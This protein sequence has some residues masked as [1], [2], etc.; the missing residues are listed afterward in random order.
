LDYL[1]NTAAFLG[2]SYTLRYRKGVSGER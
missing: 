2:L 1:E